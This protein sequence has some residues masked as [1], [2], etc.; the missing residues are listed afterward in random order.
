MKISFKLPFDCYISGPSEESLN[1]QATFEESGYSVNLILSAEDSGVTELKNSP[2]ESKYFVYIKNI[3]FILNSNL[4]EKLFQPDYKSLSSDKQKQKLILELFVRIVNR[5][6]LAIRNFG[7]VPYIQS[8]I[9]RVFTFYY[10][11]IFIASFYE[12]S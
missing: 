11:Y 5:S 2:E 8:Y 6:L 12:F 7:T 10:L 3:K 1:L 9:W 4:E